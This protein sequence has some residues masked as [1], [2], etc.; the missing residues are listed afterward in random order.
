MSLP[1]K[2]RTIGLRFMENMKL[3]L[4]PEGGDSIKF[5]ARL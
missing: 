5:K 4:L 2:A 1:R 3:Y